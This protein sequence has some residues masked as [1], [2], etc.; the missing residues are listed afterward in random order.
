MNIQDRILDLLPRKRI[1]L[2]LQGYRSEWPYHVAMCNPSCR[3]VWERLTYSNMASALQIIYNM[4]VRWYHYM[5]ISKLTAALFSL[6]FFGLN[7][8]RYQGFT[9]Y[10]D[11]RLSSYTDQLK[12]VLHPK[13]YVLWEEPVINMIDGKVTNIYND[14]LDIISKEAM[15]SRALVY[16]PGRLDE[17]YGN[18]ITIEHEC[19][20][21]VRY[22]GLKRNSFLKYKL[23]DEVKAGQVLGQVGCSGRMAK[24]PYLHIEASFKFAPNTGF[25][26]AD[27]TKFNQIPLPAF[28][29]ESF[30][31]MPLWTDYR[32]TSE[33][34]ERMYVRD[35]KYIL[36]P[37]HFMRAG[38][39][40]KKTSNK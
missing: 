19:G 25:D 32:D 21:R 2:P 35:I 40:V 31:E 39:L 27:G 26:V 15:S 1:L 37:G 8:M 6:N 3:D 22:F 38:S 29:F 33:G 23:G 24:R 11:N 16:D 20:L 5:F 18:N 4:N 28:N 17:M 9:E 36:N 10:K 13:E 30:Y 12:Y 14:A 34:I 7:T